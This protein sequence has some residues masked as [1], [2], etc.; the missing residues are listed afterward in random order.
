MYAYVTHLRIAIFIFFINTLYVHGML[1]CHCMNN[2]NASL[3][4]IRV[5]KSRTMRRV[6][7]CSMHGRNEKYI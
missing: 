2:L 5:I 7:A 3:N 4:I 1:L 6:R